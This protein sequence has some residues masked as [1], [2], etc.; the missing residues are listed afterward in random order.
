MFDCC[1]LDKGKKEDGPRECGIGALSTLG[2]LEGWKCG[3]GPS[4]CIGELGISMESS[5]TLGLKPNVRANH[6][7]SIAIWKR[8]NT[9]SLAKTY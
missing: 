7:N 1:I 4:M 3:M 2:K 5:S 8:K 6:S 9:E